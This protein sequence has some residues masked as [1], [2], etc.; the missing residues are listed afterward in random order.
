MTSIG[1]LTP[2]YRPDYDR[3]VRLH[4]SVLEF[5]DES[6]LHHV[7][8]PRRDL[9]LFRELESSGCGSGRKL[10]SCQPDS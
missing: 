4:E 10:I 8:V 1:I 7:I 2:S 9:A 5:T 3:L 6:V